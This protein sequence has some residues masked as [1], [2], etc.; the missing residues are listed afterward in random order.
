MEEN[1]IIKKQKDAAK[2]AGVTTRTIRRWKTRLRMKMTP[3]GYYIK[4]ELN[5]FKERAAKQKAVIRE[6]I[7]LLRKELG[8]AMN[9][10]QRLKDKLEWLL[11][12]EDKS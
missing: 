6:D 12:Q 10:L 5:K 9:A 7:Q 11:G 8:T 1:N 2:Y 3:K 4:A